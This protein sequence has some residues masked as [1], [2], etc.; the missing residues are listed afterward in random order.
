MVIRWTKVFVTAF[1][2]LAAAN[3]AAEG[4]YVFSKAETFSYSEASPVTAYIDFLVGPAPLSGDTAFSRNSIE[5]GVG[6]KGLELSIVHR[7]DYNISFT[8]DAAQFAYRNKNRIPIPLNQ[9]YDVDVWAN[10]Y[11]M[12][13]AKV[14]YELPLATNFSLVMAYAHLYGTEAVSGYMGKGEN[15]EDGI[16]K[17]VEKEIL[18][19]TKKVIDGTLH[20]DYFYTD[21]PLFEREVRAPVGHG[22]AVDLGFNWQVT[23]NLVVEGM[24][25]DI[26]G[27][28]RWNNMPFTVA[29]ATS[30]TI[31]EDEDGFLETDPSFKGQ[32][33]FGRFTQK[34]TERRL[35][36]ARYRLNRWMLGYQYEGYDVA[37]LNRLVAGYHWSD[38]WGIDVAG[39]VK[40]S[41]I[42][43]RLWTP[44]GALSFTTDNLDL[45]NA[46]TLGFTWDLRIAL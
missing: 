9:E 22:Y 32:E 34:F 13:G 27:E 20:A 8:P 38:R 24:I 1:V 36:S 37:D 30:E 18:G 19:E 12:S 7:N 40:T 26:A 2:G 35:L 10:Q 6:Y 41:A 5:L 14:G 29:R 45:D 43:L 25:Q 31:F 16:I 39:E 11:Q 44:A 42:E 33:G 17:M 21:D 3:S 23:E 15:G 28:M 46:H 4:G